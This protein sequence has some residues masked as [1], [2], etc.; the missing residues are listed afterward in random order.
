MPYVAV[1]SRRQW[2]PE[3]HAH[4]GRIFTS[5]T[6][7]REASAEREPHVANLSLG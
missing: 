3:L 4:H 2:R 5:I 7:E 6:V 1:H